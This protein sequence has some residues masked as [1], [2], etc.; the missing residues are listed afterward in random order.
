MYIVSVCLFFIYL[1]NMLVFVHW[2][3]DCGRNNR[4]LD[5]VNVFDAINHIFAISP[6]VC[7]NI[8]CE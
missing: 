5:Q 4:E 1:C 2:E 7:L 8:T 6:Q 3:H